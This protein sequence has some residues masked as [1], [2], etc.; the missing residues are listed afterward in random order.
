MASLDTEYTEDIKSLRQNPAREADESLM[1]NEEK[2]R[3]SFLYSLLA[4]LL[5]GRPLMLLRQVKDSNGL[6]AYRQLLVS[7]E[8]V[9]RNRS[10][11]L[12]NMI[13]GW[14]VFDTKKSNLNQLLRLEETFREYERTGA[15]LADE[16][17]FSVLMRCITGQLKT[18]LQLQ[19]AESGSYN[20]LREAIIKYDQATQKWS[21]SMI[22][23]GDPGGPV[24]TE[25]DRVY[26]K[27]K[28]KTKGKS[29]DG[30]SKGGKGKDSFQKGKGKS[31]KRFH[32][33]GKG[34]KGAGRDDKGKGKGKD[35]SSK[36]CF[37]CG[38]EG[39]LA[40]DCWRVRQVAD[41]TSSVA[42][43]SQ[44]AETA[45]TVASSAGQM[46]QQQ[47]KLAVK[48]VSQVVSH[49]IGEPLVFDLRE[50][51]L[52]GSSVRAIQFFNMAAEDHSGDEMKVHAIREDYDYE[53]SYDDLE[54]TGGVQ[55]IILD[56]GSDAT[57]LPS[58]F[59]NVGRNTKERALRLQDDK[60]KKSTS[61][62]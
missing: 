29:K 10:L 18:W 45:S 4:S 52:E 3:S 33:K 19:V 59:L 41:A 46:Q 15:T 54:F 50:Q 38:R 28:G 34:D 6:E 23:G 31:D 8:P 51:S 47:T 22:L 13:L 20:D 56:S 27:G 2:N 21:D 61:K 48:R 44:A 40:R 1:G 57:I 25:V 11:G 26:E 16:I 9:S 62:A 42:G 60:V 24:P 32:Q 17:K 39:H 37:N 7:L 58:S 35:K 53:E 5:K 49:G 55:K 36:A 30:K 14:S 43:A 12:L